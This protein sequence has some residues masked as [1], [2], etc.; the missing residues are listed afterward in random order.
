VGKETSFGVLSFVIGAGVLAIDPERK[1]VGYIMIW[2]GIALF[3]VYIWFR[4]KLLFRKDLSFIQ[5]QKEEWSKI[6]KGNPTS[7]EIKSWFDFTMQGILTQYG[8]DE[9]ELFDHAYEIFVQRGQSN[10]IDEYFQRVE[11]MNQRL[12]RMG[13]MDEFKS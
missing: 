13:A 2:C 11:S 4:V 7:G 10:A 3:L 1:V 5:R 6:N 8:N 9:A 12:A